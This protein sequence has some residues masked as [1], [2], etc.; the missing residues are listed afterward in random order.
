MMS[1]RSETK[2]QLGYRLKVRRMTQTLRLMVVKGLLL[3]SVSMVRQVM[4]MTTCLILTLKMVMTLT[5]VITLMK[6]PWMRMRTLTK[7]MMMPTAMMRNLPL[8]KS[9]LQR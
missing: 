8:K 9:L 6:V 2:A 7:M 4:K 3:N 1:Q 5:M